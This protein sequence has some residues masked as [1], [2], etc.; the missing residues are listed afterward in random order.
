MIIPSNEFK[1]DK[2]IE[3]K[4][5]DTNKNVLKK[6]K[7]K[8]MPAFNGRV[9]ERKP[10]D[11]VYINDNKKDNKRIN[12]NPQSLPKKCEPKTNKISLFRKRVQMD[13]K[14]FEEIEVENNDN[15]NKKKK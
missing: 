13:D 8:N 10:P 12:I 6:D 1:N 3:N 4:K 7:T 15:N 2:I 14:Y 9:F 5:L 11:M